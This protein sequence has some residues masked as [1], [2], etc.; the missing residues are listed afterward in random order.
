M[1]IDTLRDENERL[2][3]DLKE[4]KE[5]L[6]DATAYLIGAASAYEKY[7]KRFGGIKPK[8]VI[9]PFF[10]TRRMDFQKAASRAQAYLNK[11]VTKQEAKHEWSAT[12]SRCGA[13]AISHSLR[14]A[15]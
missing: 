13:T 11:A 9:D 5:A 7:A 3:A 12:C 6:I 10:E 1:T 4:M 8:A 15:P 14:T 2:K